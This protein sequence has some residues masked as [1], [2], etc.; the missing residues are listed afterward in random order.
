[1]C[2]C[3]CV[4]VYQM[5][6]AIEGV[7]SHWESQSKFGESKELGPKGHGVNQIKVIRVTLW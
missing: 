3:V 5:T 6:D 1:M 4:C 2:V 7:E